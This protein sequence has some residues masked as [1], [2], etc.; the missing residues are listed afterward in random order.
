MTDDE[1]NSEMEDEEVSDMQE[2]FDESDTGAKAWH[3]DEDEDNETGTEEDEEGEEDDDDSESEDESE[4]DVDEAKKK[5]ADVPFE[6]LQQLRR[7]GSH[8]R[9]QMIAAEQKKLQGSSKAPKPEKGAPTEI[10]SKKPV[11]RLRQVV[12]V[13]KKKGVDP[14]F[15]RLSGN[16]NENLFWKTYSFVGE[17]RQQE[18]SQLKANLSK[19]KNAAA[20]EAMREELAELQSQQQKEVA[21]AAKRQ[22]LAERRATERK[23]VEKGKKPFYL[24]KSDQRTLDLVKRY[25]ELK[26]KKGKLD[27]VVSKRRKRVA[28]KDHRYVPYERRS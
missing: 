1:D 25:E 4:D 26:G 14:R 5:L 2:D 6:V 7:D 20:R 8:D 23:A 19:T 28:Q 10:S 11:S 16:L 22:E 9:K 3:E 18:I 27:D 17:K 21:G 15:E 13:A 24:K 12:H